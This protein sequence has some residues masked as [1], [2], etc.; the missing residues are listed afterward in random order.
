MNLQ[1]SLTLVFSL[2]L[3]YSSWGRVSV[4]GTGFYKNI[5][6]EAFLG[7]VK[8]FNS[9][10]MHHT[11]RLYNADLPTLTSKYLPPNPIMGRTIL[12]RHSI[13]LIESTGILT[14]YPSVT[15]FS[16]TLGPD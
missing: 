13:T 7:S 12:L 1:S 6:L 9:L 4:L 3:E 10:R 14:C 2:A 15:L 8:S 16:L 11:S 5:R